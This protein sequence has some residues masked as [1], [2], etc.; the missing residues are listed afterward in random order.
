M[1]LACLL[2]LQLGAVP[3]PPQVDAE[4]SVVLIK[5]SLGDGPR[6]KQG[7]GVVVAP[8]LVATNA[9]VIQGGHD[10]LVIKG[11]ASWPVTQIRTDSD[12]DL[13]LLTVPGL[14]LPAA[15]PGP[16]LLE[17]GQMVFSVGYPEGRGPVRAQGR[18]LGN[19]FFGESRLLQSDALTHH[20]SSGG[21]LFDAQGRLLGLTTFL[22]DEGSRMAF[23]VPI[24]WVQVLASAPEDATS[25]ALRSEGLSASDLLSRL[26][27]DPRNWP[28]WE[29]CARTWS[30]S[31]P[32]DPDAWMALGLALDLQ[33]RRDANDGHSNP[34]PLMQ[35][36]AQ[37]FERSV[38]FR[39]ASLRPQAQG[40]NALGVVLDTLNRSGEAEQAFQQA[41]RLDAAY[42][43]A[44]CNL[45]VARLNEKRYRQAA[46][47]FAVGLKH[48]PDDGQ[49]W[50]RY[51]FALQ[52]SGA[53]AE[54]VQAYVIALR[55]Q[56]LSDELWWELGTL[57]LAHHQKT[58]AE[59]IL[60][61]LKAMNS[62]YATKLQGLLWESVAAPKPRRVKSR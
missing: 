2:V 15:E 18:L 10:P 37:C 42:G 47:A 45:G 40:W 19:W 20:G 51:A 36:A 16:D 41:I 1:L 32:D 38:S 17:V 57:R 35:E 3:A 44:W 62:L 30:M 23:S 28:G 26:A 61:R 21:G 53:V 56:P 54:S 24:R 22:L 8:G 5:T 7:S 9:H 52:K 31:N 13:C 59:A 39:T 46:D 25:G 43:Q 6:G 55:Y 60:G 50:A 49:A 14:P 58:E 27:Q 33:A 34:L 11:Q 12:H 29:Q 4:A 48:E